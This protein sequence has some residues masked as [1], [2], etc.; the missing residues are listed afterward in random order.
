MRYYELLSLFSAQQT[1]EDIAGLVERVKGI[2]TGA[3]G[4]IAREVE[5]GKYRLTYPIGKTRHASYRLFVFK[6]EPANVKAIEEKLRLTPDVVRSEISKATEAAL[7]RRYAL[8]QYEEPL[9]ERG[10]RE[11][12]RDDTRYRQQRR[13]TRQPVVAT[14]ARPTTPAAAPLSTEELEK[15]IDKILDDKTI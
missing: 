5:L 2:V 11:R 7:T 13:D 8:M 1:D 4:E 10:D 15:Q 9:I 6:S 3:G 12:E 14:V